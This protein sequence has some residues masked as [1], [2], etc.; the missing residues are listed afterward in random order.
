MQTFKLLVSKFKKKFTIYK[1]I[2]KNEVQCK[3]NMQV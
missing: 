1:N 3:V 2:Y